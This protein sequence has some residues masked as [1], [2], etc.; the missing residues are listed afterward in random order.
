[1][2]GC[3]SCCC[4]SCELAATPPPERCGA[5]SVD[6]R[7]CTLKVDHF[8]AHRDA[9]LKSFFALREDEVRR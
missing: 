8:G 2:A 3:P 9:G 4:P 6:G 5:L 7:I 1:M